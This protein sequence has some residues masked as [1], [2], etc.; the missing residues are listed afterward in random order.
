MPPTCQS[1]LHSGVSAPTLLPEPSPLPGDLPSSLLWTLA[2]LV[3]S[4]DRHCEHVYLP[5]QDS[6]LPLILFQGHS[7]CKHMC[8]QN[9]STWW[10]NYQIVF[11]TKSK[12]PFA[13]TSIC[14]VSRSNRPA[15]LELTTEGQP[16]MFRD[17]P[18]LAHR[19]PS[20]IWQGRGGLG[21][22]TGAVNEY[23]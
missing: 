1:G 4:S 21:L 10:V 20:P 9:K 15:F 22:T 23:Q 8:H 2:T 18:G 12:M 3:R 6:K 5:F 19:L 13:N 16:D 11:I 17:F 7:W 14:T